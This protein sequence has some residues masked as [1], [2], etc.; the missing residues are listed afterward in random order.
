[1]KFLGT[2]VTVIPLNGG[3]DEAGAGF[4]KAISIRKYLLIFIVCL[5]VLL[6]IEAGADEPYMLS[7]PSFTD[8]DLDKLLAPI[9]LY[10][11]PLLA[12]IL[13]ASTYPAEIVNAYNWL[14]SGGSMSE[15]DRQNWDE[16][17]KAIARYPDILKMMAVNGN[18]TA[19]LGDAF[20]SQPHD[21]TRSIQRLRWKARDVGNLQN[22]V[23]QTVNIDGDYIE[24]IPA[25]PQYIYVPLY[26]P[27]VVYVQRWRPGRPSF[28]TFGLGL[29][30][31]SWLTMDF[32]WGRHH[33]IYHGWNRPGWVNHA[34]PHVRVTNVYVTRSRP[35]INNTWRH[36]ASH[37]SPARYRALQPGG[38]RRQA[39]ELAGNQGEGCNPVQA[40]AGCVRFREG[41]AFFQQSWQGK[42]WYRCFTADALSGYQAAID[43]TGPEHRQ[44]ARSANARCR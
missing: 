4:M 5:S 2:F 28:I 41:S 13:P 33:I 8:Q 17:V 42:P 35:Y 19:D 15:I 3:A 29:A 40:F 39:Y 24:V 36:D 32:D 25:Q 16:S 9:A 38:V 6:P 14:N 43:H 31:G 23:Q 11:D 1:M 7:P 27:S 22:T 20:L 37:G 26:D 12:Q 10:P 34:R 21:V 18:W 30:I 44:T